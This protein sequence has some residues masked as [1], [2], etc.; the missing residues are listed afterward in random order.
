MH[1]NLFACS[2]EALLSSCVKN[3][4]FIGVV[5]FTFLHI[6]VWGENGNDNQQLIKNLSAKKQM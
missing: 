3:Q 5:D 1:F 2:E 6:S 4:Q